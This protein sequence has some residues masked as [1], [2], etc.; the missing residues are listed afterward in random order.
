MENTAP[1][2][3]KILVDTPSSTKSLEFIFSC[4]VESQRYSSDEFV[5]VLKKIED[6]FGEEFNKENTI[7]SIEKIGNLILI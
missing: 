1:T 5:E 3:Y 6:Y 7:K 2:L 4:K